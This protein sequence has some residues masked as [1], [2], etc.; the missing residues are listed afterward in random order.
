LNGADYRRSP[1]PSRANN[2]R[3]RF[4]Q[5]FDVKAWLYLDDS[6]S[7]RLLTARQNNEMVDDEIWNVSG[8]VEWL[9]F[10]FD[11]N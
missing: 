10:P 8:Q 1:R 2:L 9:V 4:I 11:A 5:F 7:R 6:T 3:Y